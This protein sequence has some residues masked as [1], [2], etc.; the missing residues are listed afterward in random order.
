MK[1]FYDN[2]FYRLTVKMNSRIW[3]IFPTRSKS[4]F[5]LLTTKRSEQ[6]YVQ[7]LCYFKV[8]LVGDGGL[9]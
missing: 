7:A 3:V 5:S 8:I 9:P 1:T 6:W 4:S 2:S